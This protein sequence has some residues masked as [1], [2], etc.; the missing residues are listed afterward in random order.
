MKL[1]KIRLYTILL[2]LLPLGVVLLG[3]GCDNDEPGM[4][5]SED[6]G[7]LISVFE[8]KYGESR[9]IVYQGERVEL[10]IKNVEDSVNLDCALVDFEDNQNGPL[11]LRVYSYLQIGNQGKTVKIASKPCGALFYENNGHDIEDVNDLISDMESAPANLNDD[12]YFADAFI[13]HFGEGAFIANTSFRIFMAKASP[14]NY[15]QPDADVEDYQF[16]FIVTA[17]N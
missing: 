16:V 8:L 2:L 17:K 10:S 4:H 12:S 3:G 14:T 6:I 11:A 13:N 15:N 5:I 1:R 7:D 9:E